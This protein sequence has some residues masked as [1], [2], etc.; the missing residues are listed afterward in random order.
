M[1]SKHLVRN[2]GMLAQLFSTKMLILKEYLNFEK[3]VQKKRT[4]HRF[5]EVTL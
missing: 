2:W 3:T 1:I 5:E 4:F